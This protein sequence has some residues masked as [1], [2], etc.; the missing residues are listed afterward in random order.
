MTVRPIT[1]KDRGEYVAMVRA[2]YDSDAVMHPIPDDHIERTFEELMRS[3]VYAE[4]R[5]LEEDGE[6]VG[7][8]LLAK[9]FSQEAGGLCVWVEELYVKPAHRSKGFGRTFFEELFRSLPP[10][11]KR[12]RL[13]VEDE[14]VGA[15]RLYEALGFSFMEYRS[16][17]IDRHG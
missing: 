10:A 3:D 13:E 17:V 6:T 16:M 12:I 9:T 8:A 7:Y 14:N 1:K 5:M 4:A 2:F 15:V 11:V